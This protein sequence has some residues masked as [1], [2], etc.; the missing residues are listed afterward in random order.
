VLDGPCVRS[1]LDGSPPAAEGA[2]SLQGEWYPEVPG[3]TGVGVMCSPMWL[4][5]GTRPCVCGRSHGPE[6][7]EVGACFGRTSASN[8]CH[9]SGGTPSVEALSLRRTR[10]LRDFVDLRLFLPGP[11]GACFRV[12]TE[13]CRTGRP[14]CRTR[15]E[16][17][18][19]GRGSRRHE[20][21][22]P[23]VGLTVRQRAPRLETGSSRGSSAPRER[24]VPFGV[25]NRRVAPIAASSFGSRQPSVGRIE[26]GV[27]PSGASPPTGGS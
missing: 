9:L 23:A 22:V 26:R 1:A 16:R 20:G 5:A 3:P 18:R 7:G 2:C 14:A 24:R 8:R 4:V 13:R 25:S 19:F 15:S 21:L 10:V 6:C 12:G 27:S 17:S 11:T